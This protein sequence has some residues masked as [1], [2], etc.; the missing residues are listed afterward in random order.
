MLQ[1]PATI[2][3][4]DGY[5]PILDILKELGGWPVIDGSLWNKRQFN[6]IESVYKFK[7]LGYSNNYFIK[8]GPTNG[9]NVNA[10]YVV[11]IKLQKC[12]NW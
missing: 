3:E 5:G 1:F 8:F 11:S 12:I 2:N 7:D 4:K 10:S 9:T 6:W